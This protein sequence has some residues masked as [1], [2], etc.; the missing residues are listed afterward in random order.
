MLKTV[1]ASVS[2]PVLIAFEKYNELSKFLFKNM[3]ELVIKAEEKQESSE[4]VEVLYEK[5][6]SA[7]QLY[8]KKIKELRNVQDS[9]RELQRKGKSST[10]VPSAEGSFVSEANG[11]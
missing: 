11:V 2:K 8:E 7:Y 5:L 1:P 6:A 4:N 10:P 3:S 9:L